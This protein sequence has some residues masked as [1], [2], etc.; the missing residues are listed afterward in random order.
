LLRLLQVVA[1]LG[2]HDHP[3]AGLLGQDGLQHV[4]GHD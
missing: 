3:V 1:Q 4:N 2:G